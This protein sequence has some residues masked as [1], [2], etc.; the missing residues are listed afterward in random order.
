MI[1]ASPRFGGFK[2]SVGSLGFWLFGGGPEEGGVPA[3]WGKMGAQSLLCSNVRAVFRRG[4]PPTIP[5]LF[6]ADRLGVFGHSGSSP[7][8]FL[9]LFPLTL[10]HISGDSGFFWGM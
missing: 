9:F 7:V 8:Y 5:Y 4:I 3:F 1:R 6:W 2:V 10:P